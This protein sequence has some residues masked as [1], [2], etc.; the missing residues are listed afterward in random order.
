[1]EAALCKKAVENVE[2]Q[3]PFCNQSTYIIKECSLKNKE[4]FACIISN[5][6]YY[7]ENTDYIDDIIKNWGI[8]YK[9]M[10]LD[11]LVYMIFYNQDHLFIVFKGTTSFK[12]VISNIDFIQIDDSY[13]IPGKIHRGFHNIILNNNVI[14][15]IKETLDNILSSIENVPIII[16]G[17]SLGAALA[18]IFYAYISPVYDT[19]ELIT[20]GSPRVGDK[21]FS[22]K[23]KSKRFV[24]GNDI[25]TKLPIFKYKHAEKIIRLGNIYSCKVFT[26]HFLEGYYTEL[27]K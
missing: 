4:L 10:I 3:I 6:V 19:V 15:S 21:E 5:L 12:E 24:Y 2:N 17:H 22:E 13:N 9:L 7:Y 25:I 18:T 8:N 1:M 20:F 16:T 26:D 11:S 23:I 14:E 27:S